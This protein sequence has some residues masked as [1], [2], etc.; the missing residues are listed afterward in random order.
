MPALD[1]ELKK[2]IVRMPAGEKDKLLLRL[3]TKDQLLTERLHFELIEGSA[4]TS[5]RRDAIR[6]FI[7]RT[8]RLK[9]DSA[10][11]VMMDMRTASGYITRH[12]KV[13]KDKYG[14]VDLSL[15]LLNT[16]YDQHMDLLRSYS[17]RSDKA[18]QYIAKR[19]EQMLKKL[20]KLDPDYFIEFEAEVNRLLPRVHNSCASYYARQLNLPQRW[21]A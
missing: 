7:D 16:F 3:I 17:S 18:A 1:P 20:A 10:G 14:D 19:T 5:E 13:T 12:V 4:T 6:Q 9:Q 8:A 11:W 21:D 15:Y 2:A